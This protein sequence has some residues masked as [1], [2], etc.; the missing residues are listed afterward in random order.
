MSNV[1]TISAPMHHVTGVET[2]PT[3]R[4]RNASRMA[5]NHMRFASNS[6]QEFLRMGGETKPRS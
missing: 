1:G 5:C 6:F 3:L 4:W 2:E